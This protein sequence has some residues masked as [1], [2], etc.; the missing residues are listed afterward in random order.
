MAYWIQT[1]ANNHNV[2]GYKLFYCDYISDIDKLPRFR[3]EGEKQEDDSTASY[4][5]AY[6]SECLCLENSCKYVLGKATNTWQKV[7][8]STTNSGNSGNNDG[9]NIATNQEV[10][11]VL[12]GVFGSK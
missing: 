11:D 2:S 4:P 12:N 10:D 9:L 6:G 1:T 5:C 3:I 8:Y 7:N